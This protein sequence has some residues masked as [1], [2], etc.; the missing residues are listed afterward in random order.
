M[1]FWYISKQTVLKLKE[2][3][4]FQNWFYPIDFWREFDVRLRN[5]TYSIT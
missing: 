2:E 1:E 5:P 3:E 4:N